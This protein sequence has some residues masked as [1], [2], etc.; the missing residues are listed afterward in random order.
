MTTVNVV[1]APCGY[2]KTSWAIQYMNEMSTE[3]HKFI[4]VTPFLS[5]V[6]RVIANVGSRKFYEP[7]SINGL[8]K[9][10][11]LHSLLALGR[12]IVTTHS[13]FQSANAE[14]QNLICQNNYTLILDEV[15]NVIEQVPLKK[16]DLELLL[17]AGA[18]EI[19]Q[20]T[21]GLKYINWVSSKSHYDTEYN[22]IKTMALNGNLMYCDNSAIIWNLPCDL[23]KI[24]R[25]VFIL[26]YLFKGQFQRYYYDL[27]NIK[28]KYL[29]VILEHGYYKLIP[30]SQR[31]IHNKNITRSLIN[32]YKGNLNDIGNKRTA[33]STTWYEK[34]NKLKV[35]IKNNTYNFF[36]NKCKAIKHTSLWTCV[37]GD[38]E[39]L[40]KELTP[41]GHKDSFLEI[42]SRATNEYK[43]RYH[44][45]YLANRFMKPIEKK[46]FEQYGI[47][48]DEEAWAVSELIQWIWR[49][50]IREGKPIEIYIPSSRMR[51]FLEVYL[52]SDNFESPPDN[53]VTNEPPSDWHLDGF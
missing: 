21:N 3:S 19:E 7:D 5:E 37:K 48:V 8:T 16:H 45:A 35:Q 23:F 26:T 34:N 22:K 1:D 25:D 18:I 49:S 12:D 38:N 50:R 44:L 47:T 13:L 51:N 42:T 31:P 27:H 14:T 41:R 4:Y 2:G 15:M 46:F 6:K 20:K 53:A 9:L 33:L 24:F 43:D 39:K 30:Y 11:D 10:E 52:N 29:S 36:T 28:Y 17:D 32:I 40:Q